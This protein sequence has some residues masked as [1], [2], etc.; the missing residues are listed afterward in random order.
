MSRILGSICCKTT[1]RTHFSD[2]HALHLDLDFLHFIFSKSTTLA[3]N[4]SYKALNAL[5]QKVHWEENNC[6]GSKHLIVAYLYPHICMKVIMS[7]PSLTL[8]SR[9][10]IK[11]FN[12]SY[13]DN[14]ISI[15]QGYS[16]PIHMPSSKVFLP[17]SR[18]TYDC[19]S[20]RSC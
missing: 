11:T 16:F 2:I 1:H 4:Y 9:C 18:K 3:L 19:D 12:D 20:S 17:F 5:Y 8:Q 14:C 15:L 7:F 10:S 13:P 6:S